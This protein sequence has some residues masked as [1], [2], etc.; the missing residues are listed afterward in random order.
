MKLVLLSG[1]HGPE[2]DLEVQ[3]CHP[4]STSDVPKRVKTD[5]GCL[6]HRP[7]AIAGN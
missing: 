2:V 5:S 3:I 7:I 6:K 4:R 1:K